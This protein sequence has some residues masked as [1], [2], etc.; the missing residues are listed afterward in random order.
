MASIGCRNADYCLRSFGVINGKPGS[1][2]SC[3]SRANA[4]T[5][6]QTYPACSQTVDGEGETASDFKTCCCKTDLCNH[7]SFVGVA[8]P[9]LDVQ[10]VSEQVFGTPTRG[11]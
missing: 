7:D 10:S 9:E 1:Y 2:A 4:P 5:T 6:C 3:V 11:V 8:A